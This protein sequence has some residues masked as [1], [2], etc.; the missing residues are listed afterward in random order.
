MAGLVPNEG[1]TL[2]GE[3]VFKNDESDRPADLEIGLMTD[4]Q[5]ETLA[6]ATINEPTGTGYARQTLTDASWSVTTGVASYAQ[7]TFTGG[8]GGWTGSVT[9][10]FIA[11]KSGGG[12]QRLLV[13]EEDAGGPY[14]IGEGDTYKITPGI[15]FS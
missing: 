10:Y 11:T 14:T 5:G 1:E 4:T 6:E 12:T 7:I 2:M 15:T 9:G 8:S 3:L 13:V